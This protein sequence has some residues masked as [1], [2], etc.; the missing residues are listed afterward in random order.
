MRKALTLLTAA[1]LTLCPLTAQAETWTTAGA[2]QFAAG[3]LDGVSVR[4]TGEVVLAPAAEQ[5]EGV[6]CE[7]V[8]D[9]EASHEGDVYVGTGSPGGVFVLRDDGLE[10]LYDSGDQHVLSVLPLLDGGVLAAVVP[11]DV[12]LKIDRQGDVTTFAEL[13][14]TYVW[15]MAMGP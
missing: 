8:W 9:V 15:D 11:D 5:I 14:E 12:M 4:S 10:Q 13:E 3:E 6:E 2:A 1:L 7:F